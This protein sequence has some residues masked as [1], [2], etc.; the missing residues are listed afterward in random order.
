MEMK[1]FKRVAEQFRQE[2]RVYQKVLR[3]PRTPLL[4]KILLGL[5]IGYFVLPI[6]LI[7]DFIPFFGQLDD[8]VIVPVLVVLAL[9]LIPREIIDEWRTRLRASQKDLDS[10]EA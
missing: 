5:A 10:T 9:K 3:D 1:K 4:P 2:F 8:L 7:P 6:D